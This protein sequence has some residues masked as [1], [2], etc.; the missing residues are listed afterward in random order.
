MQGENPPQYTPAEQYPPAPVQQPYPSGAPQQQPYPPGVP[1]QQPYPPGAPQQQPYPPGAPQQQPYPP[2]Q[3]PQPYPQPGAPVQQQPAVTNV[4]IT[5]HFGNTSQRICCTNCKTEQATVIRRKVG[6]MNWLV[7]AIIA[8]VLCILGPELL[9]PFCLIPLAFI[10]LC[11]PGLK[12]VEHI[13]PN[14]NHVN[15]VHKQL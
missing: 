8:L 6:T 7:C 2:A 10:A 14:C 4:V 1:Q 11:I 13:C 5:T 9:I 12:D 3:V 15:G